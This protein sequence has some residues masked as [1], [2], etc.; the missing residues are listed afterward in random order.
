VSLCEWA[1]GALSSGLVPARAGTGPEDEIG[2]AGVLARKWLRF[3]ALY[4]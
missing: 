3:S 2:I 4:A 1:W